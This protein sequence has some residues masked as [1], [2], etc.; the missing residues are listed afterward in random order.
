MSKVAHYLQQHVLGEVT[1]AADVRKHFSTDSGVFSVSPSVV[2]Y[3]RGEKDV[4]KVARFTWQ[5][6]ER[7]RAIPITA[8]GMGTDQ[9]GAAI[10][11]GIMMVFPAHMNRV[12]ELDGKTGIVTV[13]PGINY[14]RLQQT[15]HTHG[16]FLPPYPASADYSSVG[17]AIANN[18]SGEKS[19]KYGSTREFVKSLRVVLANGEVIETGRLTKRELS[20]KMGLTSLEGEIYRALDALIEENH[21]LIKGHRL[22]I[23]KNSA[24]YDIFDVK[25]KDGS[26]DLTPLIIGSQG[27]LGIVSEAVIETLPHNPETTLLVAFFDDL[28]VAEQSIKEISAFAEKPSALEFVDEHLLNFVDQQ[29]PNHLRGILNKPFSKL[30]AIIEFDNPNPR[31]QK[32]LAKKA[33]KILA[34]NQIAY[35]LETD[36]SQKEK[37]WKIR[38]ASSVIASHSEGNSKSL[39]IIQDGIVPIDKFDEYL[40]GAYALFARNGLK[41][42]IWGHGGDANLHMQPLLDLSQIGDRQKVFKLIDEYYNLV[43]SLGG[44]T[45]GEQGDGR[46]RA[47]YLKQLYGESIYEVFQKVK[48][49]F[50]PYNTLNPGVKINVTLEDI[51]PL[52]RQDYSLGHAAHLPRS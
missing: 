30:V 18:A 36:E 16:R 44:S 12:L 50:D 5:L 49:I 29:N 48:L 26:F 11:S 31:L 40:N 46:L 27:T 19:I 23:S 10:G 34:Q 51:K 38:H 35:R 14:G 3:P 15:L 42:A 32:K 45:S 43:I 7:G 6:A 39:P 1:T 24:G 22:E 41:P 25:R 4:R 47:P 9:S 13:E 20:K 28:K 2:V 17:G 52:L 33:A 8:R 21:D 37:L